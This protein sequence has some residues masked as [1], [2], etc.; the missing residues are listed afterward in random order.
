MTVIGTN[1]AAL[2]S[3]NASSMASKGLSTAMERL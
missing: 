2:R 1:T 3:A